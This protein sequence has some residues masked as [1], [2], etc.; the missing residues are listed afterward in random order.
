MT[1][2]ET[3]TTLKNL[4]PFTSYHVRVIAENPLGKSEPSEFIQVIT[5]EEGMM[6]MMIYT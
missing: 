1:G 4:K 3:F 5:Q 6:M 2:S